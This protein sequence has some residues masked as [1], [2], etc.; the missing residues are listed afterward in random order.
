MHLET[1]SN[2]TPSAEAIAAR[3]A[4]DFGIA[5]DGLKKFLKEFSL[6]K[7]AG[8][9]WGCSGHNLPVHNK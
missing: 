6:G 8:C 3:L 5:G 7:T 4:N 2:R 1:G 9:S